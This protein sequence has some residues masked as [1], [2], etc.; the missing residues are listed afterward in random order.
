VVSGER[1]PAR[2]DWWPGGMTTHIYHYNVHAEKRYFL[3]AENRDL[4][5]LIAINGNIVS[6][7]PAGTAAFL[8]TANKPFYIDPQTHAFQHATRHLKRDVSDKEAG[9][10]PRYEFK[11]SIIK[12]ARE[13]L[14][15]PFSDVIEHDSPLRPGSFLNQ[16]RLPK[17][18][19]IEA[20]CSAVGNFQMNLMRSEMDEETWEYFDSEDILEPE[21]IIAPYFYLSPP[22]YEGW[23][24]VSIAAYEATKRMYSA[25]DVYFALVLPEAL[26]ADSESLLQQL[27]RLEPTGVLLWIDEQIEE[28]LNQDSVVRYLKFLKKL[29]QCTGRLVLSHGGYLSILGCHAELGPCLD[30][31]G[32]SVNY[33]EHR[34][35]VPIGGG[36]PM[37]RFY[38]RSLH[39]RLR[40]GDAASIV[41]PMGWLASDQDYVTHVCSCRQCHELMTKK[42]SAE[43][44]FFFY[45]ESTPVTFTRRDGS[46]VRR[47]YPTPEATQAA[48]R[49]Y[50]FNKAKEFED[51]SSRGINDLI[52]DLDGARTQLETAAGHRATGHLLSWR[53][54]IQAFLQSPSADSDE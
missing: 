37:A 5:D 44:T 18:E 7:S 42:G 50:L 21:F 4:Y 46:I 14:G 52:G 29:R 23:L 34:S 41:Q 47:N 32:H 13:R 2:G 1:A 26:L 12:L 16:T 43:Q 8:A 22:D 36:I 3:G 38:L 35:V 9:E 20:I 17:R 48:T 33:G 54:G 11:P 49:H 30:G 45:G 39:S 31:V 51:I 19:V 15:S 53:K 24:R 28:D 40:H 10:P 25:N 27:E 6:H